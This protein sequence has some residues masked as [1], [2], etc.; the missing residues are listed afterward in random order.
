MAILASNG[1]NLEI[2]PE[3]F[4]QICN[5]E[6][7]SSVKETL[8]NSINLKNLTTSNMQKAAQITRNNLFNSTELIPDNSCPP[9]LINVEVTS[10]PKSNTKCPSISAPTLQQHL[11][12]PIIPK[13]AS[14]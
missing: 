3:N 9:V 13:V 7:S 5:S 1:V 12:S 8:L 2:K 10:E 14:I 4:V 6:I 11:L